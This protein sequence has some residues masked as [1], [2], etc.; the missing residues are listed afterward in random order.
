[1]WRIYNGWLVKRDGIFEVLARF[2]AAS[3]LSD[4]F[5]SKLE[6]AVS[7]VFQN[8]G[9]KRQHSKAFKV[10]RANFPPVLSSITAKR[11]IGVTPIVPPSSTPS[12]LKVQY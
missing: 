6:E 2:N 10:K 9:E 8:S 12:L 4:V 11:Y 7:E 5:V 1:M 3:Y